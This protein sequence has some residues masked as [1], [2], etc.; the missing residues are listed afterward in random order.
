MLD[1]TIDNMM[2]PGVMPCYFW[3]TYTKGETQA[4]MALTSEYS[5]KSHFCED[6]ISNFGAISGV[7]KV[8]FTKHVA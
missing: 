7:N 3:I 5:S 4:A 1:S 8:A 2:A 6:E